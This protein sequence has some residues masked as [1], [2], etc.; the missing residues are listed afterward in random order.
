MDAQYTAD[1]PR[2][3]VTLK[4]LVDLAK[5]AA[6]ISLGHANIRA[7]QSGNYLSHLKGRGMAFDET[8]LYQPGDDVRRIDWRV[9]ARTGKPHSK[10][11]KEER[12][13]PMFIAVDYRAAMAF[14][15]R[16]VFKRVQA[17]R[18]AALLAWA[19][20]QQG[21]R[22]GGQIFSEA[23]CL[24]LRPQTGKPALLRFLNA[25]VKPAYSGDPADQLDIPLSRLLHHARPGSRV[26]IL[27]D[28]RGLNAAAERH[29]ANLAKHCEVVMVHIADPLE[30]R[31]P[32]KGRYRF[33]DG[34]REILFD[35]ADRQRAQ[36]YQQR[37]ADRRRLLQKL[38]SQLRLLLIPCS[39]QQAALD[40]LTGVR[41]EYR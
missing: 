16:G 29:L 8:R 7:A 38:S 10:I 11:F 5:P 37:F 31:L 2:V 40:V 15:T 4:G 17:A 3:A 39:T 18:L 22:I 41:P 32:D 26:Y 12:E 13:R 19:A 24:E 6:A 36:V 35:T 23:G 27:S 28:F 1:N 25:L 20:L 21:D 14:A 33:T 30:I 34:L 9:T